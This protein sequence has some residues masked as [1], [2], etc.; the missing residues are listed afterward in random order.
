MPEI[1]ARWFQRLGGTLA[2]A[3]MVFAVYCAWALVHYG[4]HSRDFGW[5]YTN[6]A[7]GAHVTSVDPAGPAAGVLKAGD[8]VL[9][10][11][12]SSTLV[13]IVPALA[14]RSIRADGAYEIRIA[15]Q[16]SKEE[17][18][19]QLHVA[20]RKDWLLTWR[21]A[22]FLFGALVNLLVAA[23]MLKRPSDPAARLFFALLLCFGVRQALLVIY[24]FYNLFS[25]AEQYLVLIAWAPEPFWLLIAL[26]YDSMYR[27]PGSVPKGR[28]W[29]AMQVAFY[30]TWAVFLFRSW[31]MGAAELPTASAV[32]QFSPGQ[33]VYFPPR[34][35]LVETFS[36]MYGLATL[37][38][39]PIVGLR[40]YRLVNDIG[41]RR[42]MRW[43]VFGFVAGL[44][45]YSLILLL[46]FIGRAAGIPAL[47]PGPH[48]LGSIWAANAWLSIIPICFGYAIVRHRLFDISL[49]VRR[50]L[51][52]LFARRML[53]ALVMLPAA[54]LALSIAAD[55]TRTV[56]QLLFERSGMINI[57]LLAATAASLRYHH[58][59]R[60]WLDRRFFRQAYDSEA[61]LVGLPE[62]LRDLR[63]PSEVAAKVAAD[64]SEALHPQSVYVLAARPGSAEFDTIFSSDGN[65]IALTDDE[66][67]WHES[68]CAASELRSHHQTRTLTEQGI[69]LVV[70]LWGDRRLTGL[71]LLSDRKSEQPYSASDQGLLDA[72]A[73]QAAVL[74][75]KFR[76]EDELKRE[77]QQVKQ[78]AVR[79]GDEIA[80]LCRECPE[81][82][83]C[84]D[85]T[86]TEC[87]HDGQVPIVARPVD[88][89]IHARYR[90][91][92]LL[93]KGGM[94]AVY[95]ATDVRLKR[96]VAIKIMLND[97]FGNE[98]ALQR[99][100]REAEISARLEHPNIVR[101]YDFGAVGTLGAYLVMEFLKGS[102]ARQELQRDGCFPPD[103]VA[104]WTDGVLAGVEAAH[105][106]GVV[107]RDLKPEN[108]LLI[109]DATGSERIKILDFGLA[110]VT[111]LRIAEAEQ[112][113]IPGVIMGT[114][115]YMSPEQVN[116]GEVDGRADVYAVGTIV[117]EMLTGGLP[118]DSDDDI[119][120]MLSEVL[121]GDV[122]QLASVLSRARAPH[123]SDRYA[124]AADFRGALA[125]ALRNVG[126]RDFVIDR[127][128]LLQRLGVNSGMASKA[129]VR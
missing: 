24:P 68:S 30:L 93:G 42:R 27:F 109:R 110:K 16:D 100:R 34:G 48:W 91:E 113:T 49:F 117:L 70:P 82:G 38:L 80:D 73:A 63:S 33:A 19:L 59:L 45:P 5:S 106:S 60:T 43:I 62:K 95:Q 115:G 26:E 25:F 92:R 52:Y 86:V 97:L 111:L 8:R 103:V 51:Q 54:A 83:T 2:A 39:V 4:A 11:D 125:G 64:V 14:V 108:L 74:F 44:A 90:L 31:L 102:S 119:D 114:M 96:D 66:H 12:G 61:I 20:T 77:R 116:G 58:Q 3:A 94:G 53:Q 78:M 128:M 67:A 22:P 21:Q 28:I 17:R 7:A 1:P 84:Y 118:K 123:K 87:I 75:E 99:F 40:N 15:A 121:D 56:A 37:L 35:G 89:T 124:T 120:S 18:T 79:L 36:S 47:Q 72:I 98:N 57:G 10:I 41:Q 112:L 85:G 81:C 129:A 55:P 126:V 71:L 29:S 127:A 107:H 88:R 101:I 105:A 122:D 46:Q 23:L 13:E 32:I 76:L 9:S 50:G 65:H 69:R 104:R 6:S